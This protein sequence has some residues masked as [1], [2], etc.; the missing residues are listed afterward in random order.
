MRDQPLHPETPREIALCRMACDEMIECVR[1]VVPVTGEWLVVNIKNRRD[2]RFPAPPKTRVPRVL[3]LDDGSEWT[4]DG[5][6]WRWSRYPKVEYRGPFKNENGGDNVFTASE[7]RRAA[8]VRE[9][10]WTEVE[11]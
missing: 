3:T 4:F 2:A 7:L 9:N 5:R 6:W 8:D 11:A 10:P 1:Y